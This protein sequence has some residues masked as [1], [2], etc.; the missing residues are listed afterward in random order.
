[1]LSEI[2]TIKLKLDH[3]IIVRITKKQRKHNGKIYQGNSKG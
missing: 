1:M 3:F 2:L